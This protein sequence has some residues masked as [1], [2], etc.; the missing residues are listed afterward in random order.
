MTERHSGKPG[1]M[2]AEQH[3]SSAA[4]G[5]SQVSDASDKRTSFKSMMTYTKPHRLAFLG[6]FACSLLGILADLLQP[7]LVKI[8]IDDH[9]AIGNTS[10]GFLMQL[11]AV[12]LV[13]ALTGFV[14]TYVQ[15]NLLQHVGQSIVSRI[16]KDIFHH[17]TRMSM[18]FFDRYHIG[19]L[20][21]NVSRD[22][23]TISSFFTQVLLSLIRDGMML[24]LIIVFMFQLDPVLAGYSLAVL[25]VIAVVAILFRSNLRKVYQNARTRFAR[26]IAF[27]AE[28][29]AGMFL[30]QAFHQEKEQQQRFGEKNLQHL[31][32]NIRQ[33]RSHV[34]FN[35]TFDILGNAALVL[36]VWLGGRAVLNESLQVGVL[37]AFI[38]YIRQFFQPINQ[39]TMQWNTF[40]SATVSMERIANILDTKPEVAEPEPAQ[41]FKLEPKQVMGQIDFNN[42]SFGYK[43]GQPIISN[44][45]LHLYPGEMV[46]IVGTTGAGKSTLISLLNRFYDVDEGSIDI[47]GFDI[48][49]IPQATLHRIVGLIQQE[50]FLFS[51]SIIENVR[52]FR[53]DITREQAIEA[54]RFVGADAMIRRLP[55]GYETPL[56]ERGSGLS[57]GER[58][59]ISFARIVVFQPRVLILDEATANLDSHTE[60]LVQQALESVSKGRTTIVIAHR[61]STIMHADRIIVMEHGKIAEEGTHAELLAHGG[62]Y[63]Q[64]VAHAREAGNDE[65]VSS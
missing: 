36:M 64:L 33:A 41:A 34:I 3:A 32:A 50:P 22:T 7:Y 38:S 31:Q 39:I 29:L 45:D 11:A 42:V 52:M 21:T 40:Q 59:L 60:L 23:E 35:R 49:H 58:Q 2:T 46:G 9:L 30:I 63:A 37:Y 53:E 51:G 28:N 56:S 19:S 24:V 48:R 44:M 65:A 1:P 10:T 13:L 25:P 61:L 8:A 27:T 16:R 57:A 6:I 17:I 4:K 26:L 55:E 12:Y 47:D 5:D 43:P 20:V 54:C 14:F 62:V 18:S 15:N